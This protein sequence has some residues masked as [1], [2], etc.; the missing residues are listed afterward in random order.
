MENGVVFAPFFGLTSET[1]TSEQ[2]CSV[3]RSL[4]EFS[5]L[6]QGEV[7]RNQASKMNF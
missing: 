1:L 7:S 2:L 5:C 4:G 6:P 3:I